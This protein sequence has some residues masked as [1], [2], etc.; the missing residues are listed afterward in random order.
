M[1]I[2]SSS[3]RSPFIYLIGQAKPFEKLVPIAAC[4]QIGRQ[5]GRWVELPISDSRLEWRGLG[6]VY[7]AV[8]GALPQGREQSVGRRWGDTRCNS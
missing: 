4:N 2:I 8:S 7:A 3:I 6:W 1:A 5:V